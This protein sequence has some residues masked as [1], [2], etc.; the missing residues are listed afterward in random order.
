MFGMVPSLLLAL[1]LILPSALIEGT[2]E[3]FKAFEDFE[4][5]GKPQIT[6]Q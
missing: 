5:A 6:R 4:A 2:L 1:L 3:A